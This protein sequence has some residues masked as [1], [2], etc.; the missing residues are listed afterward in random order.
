MSDCVGAARMPVC[1][2]NYPLF[3]DQVGRRENV[4][5]EFVIEN[6]MLSGSMFLTYPSLVVWSDQQ[7]CMS[8]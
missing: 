3:P 8:I 5:S 4:Q 1:Q 7:L 6:G 2:S